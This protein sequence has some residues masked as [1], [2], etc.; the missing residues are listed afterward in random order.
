M[1][2]FQ[3]KLGTWLL[4]FMRD[5]K[6]WVLANNTMS[7]MSEVNSVVPQG[8][9]FG[10]LLFILMIESINDA[11]LDGQLGLFAD[12]TREGIVIGREEDAIIVQS[13]LDKLGKWSE[14]KN[15]LVN[16]LKFECLQTGLNLELKT[17]YNYL[18]PDMYHII[19]LKDNMKDLGV[20]MSA[21]GNF[22]YHILKVIS[23]VKQ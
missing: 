16:N 17:Q 6:Q 11:D 1:F 20:W 14:D 13:D 23:K 19:T 18:T 4:D 10:P 9:V 3:G 5:R 8:S 12:D 22:S 21:D 2:G 15:M 7:Y